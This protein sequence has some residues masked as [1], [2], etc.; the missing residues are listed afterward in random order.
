MTAVVI[1]MLRWVSHSVSMCGNEAGSSAW[2]KGKGGRRKD[3]RQAKGGGQIKITKSFQRIVIRR[4]LQKF[5]LRQVCVF[6]KIAKN[7]IEH[8]H[9]KSH[10]VKS[11]WCH[12]FKEQ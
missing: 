3:D 9:Q 1:T 2:G 4:D 5:Y 7:Q 6:E 8:I 12:C 11:I 10:T